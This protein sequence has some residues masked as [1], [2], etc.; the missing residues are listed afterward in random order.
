MTV[1]RWL[2]LLLAFVSKHVLLTDQCRYLKHECPKLFSMGQH[3][4]LFVHFCLFQ[5]QFYRKFVDFRGIRTQ[6]IIVEG[7]HGDH[8]TSTT[9]PS[10]TISLQE[11]FS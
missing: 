1:A 6:I 3:R 10:F 8:L 11:K 5:R 9:A 2:K 7:E 4:P